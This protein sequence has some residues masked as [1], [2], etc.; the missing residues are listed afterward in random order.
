MVQSILCA[1]ILSKTENKGEQ[2]GPAVS[3]AIIMVGGKGTRLRPLTEEIPKP[4]LPVLGVPCL[5]YVIKS[6]ADVGIKEIILACGYK[7]QKI[8]DIIGN[9]ERF[10]IQISYAYEE[11][12]AGT[13][14]AV[15]LLEDRVDQRFLVASGDVL[16]DVN[17]ADM[18][19][20]HERGEAMATMALTEVDEPTEFGI[21]GIDEGM[22]II[23][24]KEKPK[25]D[26]VFSKLINA[27]VYV[28]E[29]DVLSLIP[30]DTMFDFSKD[31]FPLMLSKGVPLKGHIIDG[32]W[33]DIGRPLDLLKANLEMARIKGHRIHEDVEIDDESSL[34]ETV[35]LGRSFIKG[36]KIKN[37]VIHPF[38]K[39]EGAV[40]ENSLVMDGAEISAGSTI[41]NSILGVSSRVGEGVMLEN[42]VVA[43]RQRIS[44]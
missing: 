18:V 28:I 42:A 35:V 37:S 40:I 33:M 27:G 3:Q 13:A 21:V 39:T 23:R 9:G 16:A 12:P 4:L 32:F 38:V 44:L 36:S 41:R 11:H 19:K 17:I 6:I 22:S 8:N 20:T 2:M 43:N 31:L 26:E 15:K 14:G 25:E 1:T 30:K 10:G 7:S 5:E 24:F 29:R 34:T